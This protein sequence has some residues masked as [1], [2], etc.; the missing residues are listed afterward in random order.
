MLMRDESSGGSTDPSRA[1]VLARVITTIESWLETV[2]R[3]RSLQ[4]GDVGGVRVVSVRVR[5]RVPC[6][7]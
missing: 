1:G 7:E 2:K 4:V 6:S 3:V 5:V